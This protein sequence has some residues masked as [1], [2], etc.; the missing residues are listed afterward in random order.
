[1][2]ELS[3][4]EVEGV[5]SGFIGAHEQTPPMYSA[6]KPQGPASLQAGPTGYRSLAQA[7]ALS[8]FSELQLRRML[9]PEL[10]F[11]VTCSK[12]AYV[13]T[14]VEDIAGALGTL[15]HVRALRR[16]SVGPFSEAQMLTLADAR[17]SRSGGSGGTGPMPVAGGPGADIVVA[18]RCS[19]VA[20]RPLYKRP[21]GTSGVG[22]A[23]R[24]DPDLFPGR[25]ISGYRR[26]HG[27][28]SSG[29]AACIRGIP[30]RR[31]MD[32]WKNRGM[33]GGERVEYAV[34]PAGKT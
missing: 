2:V 20:L 1:M 15:G 5:L 22:L 6:L 17:G 13:R 32:R 21:H 10:E 29:A 26:G 8:G 16:T 23:A 4:E 11:D 9:S 18:C 28:E 33:N 12:G 25:R 34:F 24:P 27:I 14:L 7:D 3:R 31:L 19:R 30:E